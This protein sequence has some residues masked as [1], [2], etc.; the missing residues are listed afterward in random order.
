MGVD[1]QTAE[2]YAGDLEGNLRVAAR[3]R[4]VRPYRAPPVRRVHIPKGDGTKT[5]P[6][7]IPTFEDKVLQRAVAMVLEAVYE[8]DFLDCSYGFRPGRSAHQALEALWERLMEMG[9][10][11]GRWRSTSGSSSTRWTTASCEAFLD[12]RVRDGVM[13][14]A[15]GK[16]LNAGVLE[17]GALTHPEAGTPQGGVISPL[18][19]NV[20]LHE[21]LDAWFEQEVKPRLQGSGV[22]HPLR[23][24]RRRWSSCDEDDARRVHG[25]AAEAIR[26][27][28]PDAA[29]G[30]DAAGAV[31]TA[32][33]AERPAGKRTRDLRPAGL[34]APLGE[35]AAGTLGRETEDG[36]TGRFGGRSRGRG[37]VVP[38]NRHLPVGDQHTDPRAEAA[39]A[40][41]VLRH[42]R[43]RRSASRFRYEVAS[44]AQVA[45]RVDRSEPRWRGHA[46]N[47]AA[48]DTRFRRRVV[49]TASTE[50]SEPVS[51]R[52]GCGKSARPDLWGAGE[53]NLPGLPDV[54]P[55]LGVDLEVKVH[56]RPGHRDRSEPQGRDREGPSGGSGERIRG[57]TNRNRI[58]GAADQGERAS[59]REAL[60]AKGQ[61][62]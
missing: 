38:R 2:E 58:Q 3:P 45:G 57:P 32:T 10:R 21:V 40:L 27:V 7:G 55:A 51:R 16:W 13:L 33:G 15:I 61:A 14:R 43:E 37:G 47:A 20:Y 9:G 36:S 52:A 54:R 50:R 31:P 4:Q 30:E 48:S 39:R 34:H 46:L 23:G 42:H 22:A 1:G 12:Q 59:D 29:S 17:D 19:A 6:I 18:L 5:R 44:L 62:A 41:R 53:G 11:V 60:V 28:R 24:R 56:P 49:A 25:R 26:R 35:V 8:Q